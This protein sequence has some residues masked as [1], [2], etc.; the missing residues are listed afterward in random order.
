MRL[1][2]APH[3]R[4]VAVP[5]GYSFVTNFDA[6]LVADFKALIPTEGRQWDKTNRR[7]LV[8]A[9][10]GGVCARLAEAYLG[11]SVT[12]PPAAAVLSETRLLELQY[13]GRCKARDGGE[14]TA[15]GFAD[16]GWSTIWPESVLRAFFE[17]IPQRPGEK[18]TLYGVLG[19]KPDANVDDV[20]SA[21]RRLARQWH[22][23]ASSEPDAAEQFKII[24]NAYQVL[25]HDTLRRKYEAGLALERSVSGKTSTDRDVWS[26]ITQPDEH[27][28]RAPLRCGMVLC[29]GRQSLARFVISK[30][31]QFEDVVN[32]AGLVLVTSWP[33]GAT[34]FEA[35]WVKP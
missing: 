31:L 3:A 16:D 7:W 21:Y 12:V 32:A 35:K 10:Y 5:G 25:T 14:A 6:A 2:D 26:T 22:P 1:R 28:Y 33:Y 17:V 11:I 8:D 23:D 15:Y 24:S 29:E 30:I 27:G 19:I 34:M 4:L 9:Q 20:R 13:L 18:P